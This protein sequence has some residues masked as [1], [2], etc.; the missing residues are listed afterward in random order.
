MR[1]AVKVI[2]TEF[3]RIER[4]WTLIDR[5]GDFAIYK[6]WAKDKKSLWEVHKVRYKQAGSYVMGG[7]EIQVEEGEYLATNSDWGK[8][9]W[10]PSNYDECLKLIKNQ[11]AKNVN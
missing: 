9:G 1:H 2:P 10:S 11:E 5:I 3:E 4:T 8:F 6:G 7:V